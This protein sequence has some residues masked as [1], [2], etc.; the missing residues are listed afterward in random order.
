MSS[1]DVRRFEPGDGAAVRDL[2]ERAMREAGDF[3]EGVPEPDL[4]DVAGH[5]LTDAGDFLV[6][7]ADREIVGMVGLHPVHE[8]ILADRF[9]FEGD[10]AELTRMRVDPAYQ[11]RGIGRRLYAELEDAARRLGYDRIVLDVSEDN[12]S[13]RAFYEEFG[14]RYLRT[15]VLDTP[16]GQFRLATYR[17]DVSGNR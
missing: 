14:F 13:A 7:E 11:R 4:E 17:Q 16:A 9:A 6:A 10:T 8:W 3:V 1:I 5:Y 2:H 15:V 12:E